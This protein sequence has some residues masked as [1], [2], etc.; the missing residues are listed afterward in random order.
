M[1][2]RT[3]PELTAFATAARQVLHDKQYT[4]DCYPLSELVR[5]VVGTEKNL[6]NKIGLYKWSALFLLVAIPLISTLVSV[7]IT[8]DAPVAVGAPLEPFAALRG[9]APYIS[10]VLTLM[11][12]LNSIFK[13]AE[14]FHTACLMS[15][16]TAQLRSEIVADLERLATPPAEKDVL[17]LVHKHRKNFVAY[18]EQLI[19]LFLPETVKK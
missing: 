10:L 15:I 4:A 7:I 8:P 9:V 18:Q 11:T 5:T 16:K 12:L 2:W 1:F 19:G 14:R 6:R 3:P 17:D 13:P